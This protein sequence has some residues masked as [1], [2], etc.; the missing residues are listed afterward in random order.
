VRSDRVSQQWTCDKSSPIV[1]EFVSVDVELG[2]KKR[3]L[4]EPAVAV[5]LELV[6]KVHL[7]NHF[8]TACCC[9]YQLTKIQWWKI[10]AGMMLSYQKNFCST[11][12]EHWKRIEW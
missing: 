10:C 11:F 1:K 7:W 8:C 6:R 9:D 3:Y 4:T 2:G 5:I 12:G